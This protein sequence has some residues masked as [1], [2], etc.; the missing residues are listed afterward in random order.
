MYQVFL[1][2]HNLV[3]WIV[4]ILAVVA[5]VRAYLGWFGNRGWTEQDRRVGVFFSSALDTQLLLGLVLYIF[6]SPLTTQIFRN[7]GT[8]M[9][10]P[11]V[12]F[13]GLEHLFY[14]LAAVALVHIGTVFSRRAEQQSV[15][16]RNA[17][18]FF[19]LAVLLI[20]IA[21]PWSRPLIRGF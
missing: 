11:S 19:S 7:F 10:D 17:A 8:A 21:I 9:S 12:R 13:F 4:L 14:M 20:L 3:R 18:I 5:L 2:L 6:L 15:K 16:H 1:A